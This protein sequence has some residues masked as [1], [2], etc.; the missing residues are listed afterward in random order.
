MISGIQTTLQQKKKQMKTTKKRL[1]LSKTLDR[2]SKNLVLVLH[3][4]HKFD[5]CAEI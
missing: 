2:M 5:R 1:Q 4:S 3:V